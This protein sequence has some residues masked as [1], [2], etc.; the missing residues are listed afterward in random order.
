MPEIFMM[1]TT[2][3]REPDEGEQNAG[4]TMPEFRSEATLD[5]ATR[6]EMTCWTSLGVCSEIAQKCPLL[7]MM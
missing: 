6:T 7:P 5:D 3:L 4:E 1:E 2:M